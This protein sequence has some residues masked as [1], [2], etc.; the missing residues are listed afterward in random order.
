VVTSITLGTSG[1]LTGGTNLVEQ[2]NGTDAQTFAVYNTYTAGTPDWERLEVGWLGNNAVLRTAANGTGTLRSLIVRY[3][4]TAA[5]AILVPAATTGALDLVNG[6]TVTSAVGGRVRI[7]GSSST[8]GTSGTHISLV[9]SESYAPTATSTM[10]ARGLSI[11]PTVN[12]S[13]GTPGAGSYQALHI[14]VTETALPTGTNYLL[15]AGAGASGTTE[16]FSVTNAGLMSASAA[17]L[18][19]S[20]ASAGDIRLPNA[21]TLI[22]RNAANDGDSGRQ[23][24]QDTGTVADDGVFN[25]SIGGITDLAGL[26]IIVDQVNGTTALYQL[27][28]AAHTTLEIADPTGNY[29]PTATTDTKTNIYWSAGNGRYELENKRGAALRFQ[30][31]YFLQV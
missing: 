26:L 24:F 28:G 16:K 8:T 22:T 5:N 31:W 20:P 25:L 12:Y 13:A 2:R 4:G 15:W 10:L 21:S 1:I 7:G 19:S 27:A 29:T 30:L 11:S 6:V 3:A 23:F 17:A 14:G 18:G 9:L